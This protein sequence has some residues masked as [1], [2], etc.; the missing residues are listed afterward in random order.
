MPSTS[1]SPHEGAQRERRRLSSSASGV[2]TPTVRYNRAL[3]SPALAGRH[4]SNSPTSTPLRTLTEASTQTQGEG[5][6]HPLRHSDDALID[7]SPRP[8]IDLD[9]DSLMAIA[10]ENVRLQM[11]LA[12]M[13]S[14]I[15]REGARRQEEQSV[16]PV[17][18]DPEREQ[19]R[20]VVADLERRVADLERDNARLS[21]QLA[22]ANRDREAERSKST[23]LSQQ[24][25]SVRNA[26]IGTWLFDG[27][28]D[29]IAW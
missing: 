2:R 27:T 14:R 12:D 22:D 1:S 6:G 15:E 9:L 29:G 25:Q 28:C 26:T 23:R 21:R 17:D 10:Q 18:V 20:Q 13:T 5:A 19:H 7:L 24:L 16:S 3:A 4:V 11:Q 8:E